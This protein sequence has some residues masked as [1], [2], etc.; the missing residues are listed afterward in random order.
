MKFFVCQLDAKLKVY[1]CTREGLLKSGP[2]NIPSKLGFLLQGSRPA[3][4]H[5][6][7][8]FF[9]LCSTS[10]AR[11]VSPLLSLLHWPHTHFAILEKLCTHYVKISITF[12]LRNNESVKVNHKYFWSLFQRQGNGLI[13]TQNLPVVVY[14]L[15]YNL[16]TKGHHGEKG[17]FQISY[18]CVILFLCFG[19]MLFVLMGR[20]AVSMWT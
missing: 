19:D 8:I 14:L 1:V 18:I 3:N 5:F 2:Y 20:P 11:L 6:R 13:R 10:D 15:H 17:N 7:D 16:P 9:K 12:Y 4:K